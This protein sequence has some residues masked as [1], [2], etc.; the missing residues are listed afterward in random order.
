MVV[1]SSWQRR[2]NQTAVFVL[3]RQAQGLYHHLHHNE[4]ISESQEGV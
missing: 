4:G 2:K 3:D 1:V